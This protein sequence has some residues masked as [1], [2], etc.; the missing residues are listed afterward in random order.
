MNV[1][2]YE[3]AKN[4]VGRFLELTSDPLTRE[5]AYTILQEETGIPINIFR[6]VFHNWV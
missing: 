1:S 3:R 4:Y 2:Q 6:V 5:S